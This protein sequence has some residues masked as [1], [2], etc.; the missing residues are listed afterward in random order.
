MLPM[1]SSS[2]LA[3]TEVAKCLLPHLGEMVEPW[4]R[5]MAAEFA[6]DPSVLAVLER[7]GLTAALPLCREG[8]YDELFEN[9]TYYGTRLAK[10]QVDTR[11]VARSLD[12]WQQVSEPLLE[13][14]PREERTQAC[15]T[16]DLLSSTIFV[17]LSGAY[18]DTQKK[19]S[20]AMLAVLD[21]E[22]A[23]ASLEG[24]LRRVLQ[25]VT[26]TFNASVGIVLLRDSE[27]GTLRAKAAVGLEEP[28]DENLSICMGQGFSGQIFATGEA[29]I[30][31]DLDISNG[32]L[33][34]ILRRHVR[35]LWGVP[36][37]HADQ[38]TGVLLLGFRQRYEWLPT[39]RELL[40]AIADRSA[41]AIER[42]RITDALREREIQ[43]AE[44]S[45]HLLRVQEQ[46]RKHI[47][48]ELHDETGQALMVI[49]L[50]LGMLESATH[51][52]AGRQK[53]HELLEVVDRAVVG[54]RRIMGRL[55]PLVLQELGLVAAIRKEAKDLTKNTAVKARVLI[56]NDFGRLDS[57]LESAMYRVVQE[58]LH[59]VAKHAHARSVEIQLAREDKFVTLIVADDGIGINRP[60]GSKERQS[61]GLQG[62]KERITMLGG[63]VRIRSAKN[64]GTRLEIKVPAARSGLETLFA[65]PARPATGT[66][67]YR[68]N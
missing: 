26:Q 27:T 20:A 39:E 28:L 44:L 18:F 54:L 12:L 47:S 6:F 21:S 14:L 50:Y 66:S 34:P 51:A 40:R 49:R 62:M 65:Q 23:A 7:V 41:L 16:L 2:R 3:S 42:A 57:D 45:A 8:R 30:L 55:S 11:A 5:L 52:T 37:K 1:K 24:L 64:K 48:R 32:V 67:E 36:L 19:E 35:A 56:D 43:I 68:P 25:I 4:H 38:V 63:T 29:G 31:P 58:A 15:A 22:L 59:N 53:V 46:E 9:L 17:T 60:A 61:F 13:E 33:N 10:L